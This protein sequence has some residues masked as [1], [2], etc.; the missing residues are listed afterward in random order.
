MCFGHIHSFHLFPDLL[1]SPATQFCVL[2][3]IDHYQFVLSKYF[4][5]LWLHWDVANLQ[6]AALRVADPLPAAINCK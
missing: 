3:K 4:L 1:A 6:G 2:F 5:D